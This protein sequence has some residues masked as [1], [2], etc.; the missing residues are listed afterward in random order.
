HNED[1]GS[2]QQLIETE[3]LKLPEDLSE[4]WNFSLI[5]RNPIRQIEATSTDKMKGGAGHVIL[6]DLKTGRFTGYGLPPE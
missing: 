2:I 5:G 1:A 3:Y 4:K 6:F